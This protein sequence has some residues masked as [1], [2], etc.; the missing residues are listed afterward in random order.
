MTLTLTKQEK[1]M[2]GVYLLLQ[3]LVV[4]VVVSVQ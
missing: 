2:G 4:P 1:R 3:M